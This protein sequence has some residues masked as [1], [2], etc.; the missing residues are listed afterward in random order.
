MLHIVRISVSTIAVLYISFDISNNMKNLVEL[1][2][3]LAIFFENWVVWSR[4][5][6]SFLPIPISIEKP[7][8]AFL[9]Q[10]V[11][12][13]AVYTFDIR[14][15][16]RRNLSLEARLTDVRPIY[17]EF[18]GVIGQILIGIY[19]SLILVVAA[20][21]RT[22]IIV[23]VLAVALIASV[24]LFRLISIADGNISVSLRGRTD[25]CIYIYKSTIQRIASKT[26]DY[27]LGIR[28]ASVLLTVGIIFILNEMFLHAGL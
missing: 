17:G 27:I 6:W 12:L 10:L 18:A 2:K 15:Q 3:A 16:I 1:S 9:N 19:L 5:L 23:S 25:R 13:S 21:P 14:R 4:W 8:F 26:Y 11:F 24:V 22:T 28:A 7:V 20:M